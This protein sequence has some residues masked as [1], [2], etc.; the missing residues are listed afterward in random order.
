LADDVLENRSD[1]PLAIR[2]ADYEVICQQRHPL[3]IEDHDI[4]RLLLGG[5]LPDLLGEV[6]GFQAAR[7]YCVGIAPGL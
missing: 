2:A 7:S 1:L 5:D 3:Q 4:A 6:Q